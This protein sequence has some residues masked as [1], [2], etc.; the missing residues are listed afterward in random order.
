LTA[1]VNFSNLGEIQ[2]H[3]SL[4]MD[5]LMFNSVSC[6]KFV[7]VK[8]LGS[9][10]LLLSLTGCVATAPVP[11]DPLVNQLDGPMAQLQFDTK[12]L[13]Q[14][15]Q[16]LTADKSCQQDQQCKVLG[17]GSKACGGPEQ[18]IVY[19]EQSTDGKMLAITSERYA[20]LKKEQ[21]SRLGMMSTCQQ[22]VTPVASCQ[23][24][25]CVLIDMQ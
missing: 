24:S 8:M 17:I 22:L 10:A 6:L 20:K 21:Q 25:K 13:Y 3:I 18:F 12:Q 19:S 5:D 1:K 11:Q 16:K 2:S 9:T 23:S 4:T 14:R 7:L 15:L